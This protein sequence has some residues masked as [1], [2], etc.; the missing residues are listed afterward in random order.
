MFNPNRTVF[1]EGKPYKLISCVDRN[2]DPSEKITGVKLL[3][4]VLLIEDPNGTQRSVYH[5][6]VFDPEGFDFWKEEEVEDAR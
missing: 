2:D 5:W 1:L 4:S 6:E 3:G